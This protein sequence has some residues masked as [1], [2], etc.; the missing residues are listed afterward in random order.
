MEF[1]TR[2]VQRKWFYVFAATTFRFFV[3]LAYDLRVYGTEY[4]PKQGGII[5]ASNHF[6]AWDPPVMGVSVPR[7]INYMAKK[8]LFE[9]PWPRLLFLGLRAFPVDRHKGD[10][11]AI[12]DALRRL[13]R[14]VAVGIFIQGTRNQGDAQALDGAA[15]LAQR[16]SVPIVPAAI[17]REGRK[18]RVRFGPPLMPVGKSRE[19]AKGLTQA[20]MARI[21][22]LLPS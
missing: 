5:V 8:E 16:A 12:K 19:E 13:E 15:F 21:N 20:V 1:L 10:M 4:I 9:Q 3:R 22:E 6:S 17:W 7:E 11:R 14:G 18:F 2:L